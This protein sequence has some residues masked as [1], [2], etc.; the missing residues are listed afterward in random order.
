MK[1]CQEVSN[2][3]PKMVP[4]IIWVDNTNRNQNKQRESGNYTYSHWWCQGEGCCWHRAKALVMRMLRFPGTG[5]FGF[6]P[7]LPSP[8]SD[9]SSMAW[10]EYSQRACSAC[11]A[12]ASQNFGSF[13]IHIRLMRR[14]V[15]QNNSPKFMLKGTEGCLGAKKLITLLSHVS[16]KRRRAESTKEIQVPRRT[17]FSFY[18]PAPSSWVK[19]FNPS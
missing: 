5:S 3:L 9:W 16:I 19:Q 7:A 15:K 14:K 8:P 6:F 1:W 17:L 12:V 13:N 4:N 11:R 10:S 18:L 2:P